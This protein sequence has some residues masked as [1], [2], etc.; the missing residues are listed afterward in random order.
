MKIALDTAHRGR[1]VYEDVV[2]FEEG[3]DSVD[4]R[5]ASE[6]RKPPL[7]VAGATVVEGQA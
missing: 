7:N 6:S 3:G 4:L 2:A 1:V 5:F